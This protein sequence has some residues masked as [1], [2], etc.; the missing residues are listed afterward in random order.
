M[1]GELTQTHS[2]R[3]QQTAECDDHRLVVLWTPASFPYVRPHPEEV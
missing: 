3:E 2:T 1:D